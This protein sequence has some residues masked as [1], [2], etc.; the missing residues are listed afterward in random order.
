[1]ETLTNWWL[2]IRK[3][4]LNRSDFIFLVKS[5]LQSLCDGSSFLSADLKLL[6]LLC[7]YYSCCNKVVTEK[8]YKIKRRYY[9]TKTFKL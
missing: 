5:P 6:Y 1:M 9:L 4:V 8:S 2:I 7:F 3:F